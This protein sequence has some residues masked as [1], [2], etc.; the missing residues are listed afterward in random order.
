MTCMSKK[1]TGSEKILPGSFFVTG[2]DTGIGKTVVSAILML[3]LSAHYWKPVQSGT[4]ALSDS[5]FMLGLGIDHSYILPERYRLS[6]P[7]SPHLAARLDGLTISLNDFCLPDTS[8]MN[9]LIVE[10]AG[11][12][13]VPLNDQDKIIDLIVHLNLP[14]LLVA[15]SCLGTINHTLLSLEAIRR[16]SLDIIGVVMT[17][18][19]NEENRKAIERFGNVDVIAEIPVLENLEPET[20]LACFADCFPGGYGRHGNKTEHN[21]ASLHTNAYRRPAT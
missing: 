8:K 6:Q 13:M 18:D 5:E 16:H 19:K 14:V 4:D 11:G 2:T 20:L 15:R 9:H 1:S 10:G 12:L 17:G 7:L 21:L 3:G